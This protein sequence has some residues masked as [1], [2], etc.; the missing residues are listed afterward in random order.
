MN[1]WL[2]RGVVLFSWICGLGLLAAISAIFGYLLYG[3]LGSV[4][5]RLIFGDADPL[6]AL[7]LQEPVF[8]G[9]FP[10][11]VGTVA[12]VLLSVSLAI[13][14]GMAGGIYMAEYSRGG[15]KTVFGL[16]FDILAGVPSVVIGLFGFT[17]AVFLHRRFSAGIAPSLVVSS[18]S[19][20]ILVLPYIIR[21]T[22][23]ALEGLPAET[24]LIA[25][26]LGA[27]KLQNIVYVLIP[28]ALSGILSGAVLAIGR[29]AEDT[30]VI[31]LTGAVATAGIPRS[32]FA[33]Y[34]ALPFYIYYISSQYTD[35]Q[36]L[37]SGYGASL[38]LLMICGLLFFFAFMI[39]K[40][41]AYRALYRA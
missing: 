38:I 33:P 30:A 14:V 23:S 20:A 15:V 29:C 5:L 11:I 25:A 21:S 13:P 35:T 26:A 32:I 41:V 17:L 9:L 19:L 31:M 36:E 40:G 8:A 2:E 37:A 12:V 7:L 22:Q 16:F 4:N 39:K 28:K 10:A 27:T 34:E 18:L 3:G 6:A 24:K 1:R